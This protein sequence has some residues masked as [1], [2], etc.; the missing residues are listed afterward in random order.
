MNTIVGRIQKIFARIPTESAN[1]TDMSLVN[2]Q[3]TREQ[4]A[5][6]AAIFSNNV[7]LWLSQRNN[8][9]RSIK[10][11]L[12]ARTQEKSF[13]ES[14]MWDEVTIARKLIVPTSVIILQEIRLGTTRFENIQYRYGNTEITAKNWESE[15]AACEK[16]I[17]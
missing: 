4:T 2:H 14:S 9:A 17:I 7:T 13:E 5:S 11:G 16:S 10:N 12:S 3:T 8:D 15:S 6:I 1:N